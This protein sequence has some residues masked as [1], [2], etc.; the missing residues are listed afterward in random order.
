VVDADGAVVGLSLFTGVTANE[1]RGL[2]LATVDPN[3]PLGAEVRVVWGEPDGGSRKTTVEPHEQISVRAVV[4]PA[5]YSVT[6]RTE[7]HGGWRTADA[8]SR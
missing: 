5:P 8:G 3:V 7:Y 2:S 1:R 4:S 6:A